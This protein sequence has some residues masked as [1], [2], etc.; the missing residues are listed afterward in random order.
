MESQPANIINHIGLVLDA[1][2]SMRE[3]SEELIRV[4]DEQIEYLARRS[5]DMDQET[6]ISVW[7]FSSR[8]ET[9]CV[10]WDK[11]VLRLPSI[12]P[13]YRT[14]GMTALIDATLKSIEDLETTSELYGDHSFLV[15]VLTDGNE[16]HSY[17]PASMLRNRLQ[18]LKDHWTMAALVPNQT[19]LRQ[20]LQFGFPA[21]NTEI[22]NSTSAEGVVEVSRVI[23][24][25]TDAYMS[26][27]ATGTRSTTGLF[28]MDAGAVNAATVK[29]AGLTPL[30]M[31]QYVLVPIPPPKKRR[32]SKV[33]DPV[34]PILI[35]DFVEDAG[36]PY[37]VGRAYYQL[38]KPERIQPQ[39]VL[40]LVDRKTNEVF[41]GPQVRT[42][43]NLPDE[44]VRVKPDH[45]PKYHVYPQSTS[46]N[47]HL[48][49]GTQLLYLPNG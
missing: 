46:V 17:A 30:P 40:A 10:V 19:G 36:Y 41:V 32:G 3:I 6:R 24:T 45:N 47:R 13:F 49:V 29:Q 1:S 18:G 11:D 34:P 16:N 31:D 15:Y 38:S 12:R 39:K 14:N 2:D 42:L 9:R 5:K 4:A 33:G 27:R 48:V 22:W 44:I 25:A 35:K 23:R 28:R 7:T 20:A 8:G 21:G 37:R 26:A 43:L